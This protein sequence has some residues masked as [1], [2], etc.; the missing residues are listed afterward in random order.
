[1]VVVVAFLLMLLPHLAC[2]ALTTNCRTSEPIPIFHKYLQPEGLIIGGITSQV[3]MP[4]EPMEFS[5]HPD[6]SI[7]GEYIV[8][9]KNYQHTLALVFAIKE[10]NENQQILPNITLGF[11]IYESYSSATSTYLAT[12]KLLST[13]SRFVPNYK[14]SIWNNLISVIGGLYSETSLHMAKILSIYKVPQL[15]YGSVP[16]MNETPE[17]H[18]FYQMVP[19]EAY[20]YM[21]ILQLLLHFRWT[22]VG[23]FAKD[24]DNGE[25]FVQGIVSM[26]HQ[27]GICLAFLERIMTVYIG[28]IFNL[29][30]WMTTTYSVLLQSQANALIVYEEHIINLRW[31]L[32][33]PEMEWVVMPPNGKVWIVTVQ[34]ELIALP[35]Q[36]NWGILTMHGA[37]SFAIHS[38]D[39]LG[40]QNFLYTR[41]HALTKEDGFIQVFWEQAFDCAFPNPF[42]SKKPN[43]TCTGGE[44][45][46]SLPGALFEMNMVGHSYNIYNA[47]YVVAHALHA[48]QSSKPKHRTLVT[49]Q[50]QQPW[51][52][53][54]FLRRVSF[55]NS[56]GDEISFD[57]NGQLI[58]GFDIINW[59]TFPNQSF[60]R[61]KV[62]NLNPQAPESKMFTIHDDVITWH[63]SFNQV[64]PISVCTDSCYPGYFKRTQE[65]KPF[66]CYDCVPCP[67]GKISSQ[68]DMDDCCKC[69]EEQYPNKDQDVCILKEN[70]FLSYKEP[71]GISLIIL[72][73][74]LFLFTA[75][76]LGT[77]MKHHDT[78]IIKANNR[79]LTYTLLISLLFCFLCALLFVG[80]PERV[81]CLLRQI[82]FGIV[83][84]V[85][86]SCV[87]AKTLTVVLAFRATK[88]GSRVRNWVGKKL[89]KSI[90]LSCSL[91]QGGICIIWL[92][93]CPPFPDADMNSVTE[94]II[95]E[96]NEGSAI[97]FY[98]VLGYMGILAIV[99]LSVAFLA[100]KLPDS[101]NEAKFIT[102]SMLVFCSVWLSFV[103]T[104]L[105]T[106]GKYMVAVEIF[107]ILASSA[108]LLGCIFS[109]KCYIIVL[110]PELNN[111]EQL[112]KRKY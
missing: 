11:H 77:V 59:I 80:P 65:G 69:P 111:R 110:R 68:K 88:P 48:M 37:L 83:F 24:D 23:V 94:E 9:A 93:I 103:P 32:H 84:S 105:S 2:K 104:Y 101:F 3:F 4:T 106:K 55:N 6:L 71:L 8:L 12:M 22:W 72:S 85:A 97:M 60:H 41:N 40:F 42:D 19:N 89:A 43:E 62:G 86:L 112:I 35:F 64:L 99:S 46:G 33:L 56:V 49:L 51:Q 21:G 31:L 34:Q 82:S 5:E 50:N 53:H 45:L 1:M 109:P 58:A 54:H 67:E 26:F 30:N 90:V 14:C 39:V 29:L 70:H 79:S 18:S 52:L 25:R 20:Q 102:F 98:C 28:N 92:A 66:C 76:V 47:V 73:L 75:L 36:K 108:G 81:T 95:L 13:Q 61:V 87:L 38:N 74:S 78:P 17:V 63:N 10:I 91:I 100:R 107:S 7:I 96:C 44:K 57:Q 16:F 27:R 15:A